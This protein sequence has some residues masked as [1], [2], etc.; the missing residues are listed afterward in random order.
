[1]GMQERIALIGGT[2]AVESTPG[3]G[4]TIRATWQRRE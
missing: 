2:W 4:T 3:Q 1:M